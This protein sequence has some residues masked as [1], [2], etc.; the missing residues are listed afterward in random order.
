M[1]TVTPGCYYLIP[2]CKYSL[3]QLAVPSDSSNRGAVTPL[4][5]PHG[6]DGSTAS[7]PS[8]CSSGKT[9]GDTKFRAG[10]TSLSGKL[11]NFEELGITNCFFFPKEPLTDLPE[12]HT[13]GSIM[14]TKLRV[15]NLS[16]LVGFL[17]IELQAGSGSL[18]A[19]FTRLPRPRWLK[20]S[21]VCHRV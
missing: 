11:P 19:A 16:F 4:E 13:Y 10:T 17:L 3:L 14:D 8:L 18:A 15:R 20:A 5:R 9:P 2:F 7:S 1:Q 6:L 21:L 12:G